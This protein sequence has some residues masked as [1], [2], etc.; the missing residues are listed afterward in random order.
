MKIP[1]QISGTGAVAIALIL[2]GCVSVAFQSSLPPR[3]APHPGFPSRIQY[4]I[5]EVRVNKYWPVNKFGGEP[6]GVIP[7]CSRVGNAIGGVSDC[8]PGS[9]YNPVTNTSQA[10]RREDRIPSHA[11]YGDNETWRN[12]ILA[13][14]IRRHPALFSQETHAVPLVLEIDARVDNSTG[15][16][17]LTEVFTL[18]LIHSIFP[19]THTEDASISVRAKVAGAPSRIATEFAFTRRNKSWETILTPLALIPHPSRSDAPRVTAVF[20]Q[21][22]AGGAAVSGESVFGLTSD[23]IVEGLVCALE[24]NPNVFGSGGHN[25]APNGH[26]APN[27]VTHPRFAGENQR[28]VIRE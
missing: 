10:Q 5:T 11:L 7:A 17:V 23:S 20:P 25:A 2:Q 8:I 28:R 26:P 19:L 3:S 13:S 9:V 6:C 16:D 4:T 15:W 12:A 22:Y 1:A 14:A 24:K 18:S 27:S 21:N